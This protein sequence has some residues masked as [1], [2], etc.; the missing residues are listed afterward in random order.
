M[1]IAKLHPKVH[2]SIEM[3]QAET[4]VAI[5]GYKRRRCISLLLF[6]GDLIMLIIF[7]ASLTNGPTFH[8]T[9]HCFFDIGYLVFS[10]LA[11]I[12][13]NRNAYLT[14]DYN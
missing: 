7:M 6:A 12:G 2:K 13:E 3:Y 10:P 1:I 8:K 9:R 5:L 14:K 4:W 11:N